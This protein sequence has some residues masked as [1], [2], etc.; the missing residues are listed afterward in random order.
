MPTVIAV[1]GAVL[2]GPTA[3]AWADEWR[4]RQWHLDFLKVD[5]LHDITKGDGVTV[6]LIDTGVDAT[7]PDLR[8]NVLSPG[9]R[10][11]AGHG[12][13][14]ASL[15]AGHGHGQGGRDG[16]LGIAPK[17][18]ILPIDAGKID[19]ITPEKLK[20]G[21]VINL[22]I[23][24]GMQFLVDDA[25]RADM[26]L[27]AAAGNTTQGDTKVV[28]PGKYP[29]VIAVSGLDRDGNFAKESVQGPEV[30]LSAPAVDIM[31]AGAGKLGTYDAGTGTSNAAALVSGVAAL[32][33]AK[34]PDLSANGVINRLIKTADDKGPPGRDP[35]YGFGVVNPL[36]ALTADIPDIDYNP[37]VTNE[38]SS[39]PSPDNQAGP[40][41]NE[42]AWLPPAIG[43]AAGAAGSVVVVLAV[44]LIRR[45]RRRPP[46]LNA[47][48][49]PE[50]D[51]RPGGS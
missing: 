32:I 3:P 31:A 29:G 27:V 4:D 19:E 46:L 38:P 21:S 42:N 35:Q 13:G 51:P 47:G 50:Q 36:K 5:E 7:H 41:T 37:L 8:G 12:T 18:K 43:V 49:R 1:L 44:I 26:V 16:A 40:S 10:D 2:V 9:V 24:E 34:Y 22:S 14:M 23:S 28:A 20:A 33:R 39:S 6:T 15:I 45:R 17:A 48:H 11:T 25:L 30:V